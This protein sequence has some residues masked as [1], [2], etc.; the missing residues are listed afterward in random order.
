MKLLSTL[1]TVLIV[2]LLAVGTVFAYD[3]KRPVDPFS[4]LGF[5]DGNDYYDRHFANNYVDTDGTVT[6]ITV[7]GSAEAIIPDL[8]TVATKPFHGHR[9]VG[10]YGQ[11]GSAWSLGNG[12]FVTNAHVVR[13]DAVKVQMTKNWSVVTRVDKIIT[14][15]IMVGN[16]TAIGSAPAEL[17]WVNDEFDLALVHIIGWWPAYKDLQYKPNWTYSGGDLLYPEMPIAVLVSM[18]QD[19]EHGNI[20]K[21]PWFEIR[22]GKIVATKPIVPEG[23]PQD[24]LPWFSL[25]DVTMDIPIYP[26]DS[27]SPV[28]AFQDGVPVVIGVARALAGRCDEWTGQ[29]HW[30]SYFTR[31]DPLM[32]RALEKSL[33]Y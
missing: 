18:R 20:A 15:Q 33:D 2:T 21:S 5:R 31:I 14:R 16:G 8:D 6:E 9:A 12:Y 7:F 32:P 30:Y 19:P 24:L 13:P 28:F 22:Y 11:A 27:G 25:T 26:G 23:V 10:V 4:N 1:L 29:C 3:Y 17:V